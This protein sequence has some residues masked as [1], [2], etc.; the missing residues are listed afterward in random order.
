MECCHPNLVSGKSLSAT[1]GSDHEEAPTAAV[2]ICA[3]DKSQVMRPVPCA[4]RPVT[5]LQSHCQMIGLTLLSCRGGF[6]LV[7][8]MGSLELS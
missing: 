5:L 4:V 7:V 1:F 2:G 6:A 8:V 3:S